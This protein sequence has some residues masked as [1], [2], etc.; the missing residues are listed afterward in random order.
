MGASVSDVPDC[1]IKGRKVEPEWRKR[2]KAK[3]DRYLVLLLQRKLQRTQRADGWIELIR[4]RL[5]AVGLADSN[6][7]KIVAKLEKAGLVEVQRRP[8]KRPLLRLAEPKP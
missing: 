5:E 3:R 8:G 2:R 4:H 1:A 7:Y 6:L